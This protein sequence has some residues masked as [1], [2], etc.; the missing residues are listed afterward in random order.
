MRDNRS[1][2]VLPALPGNVARSGRATTDVCVGAPGRDGIE[3]KPLP[4]RSSGQS[5]PYLFGNNVSETSS[6][7]SF[8]EADNCPPGPTGDS[9]ASR[10]IVAMKDAL[11]RNIHPGK[12]RV[13]P[14]CEL[15]A[16]EGLEMPIDNTVLYRPAIRAIAA[17]LVGPRL[18]QAA[19]PRGQR[20]IGIRRRRCKK[21]RRTDGHE[22]Y[23]GKGMDYPLGHPVYPPG[24]VNC[25]KMKPPGC[26][27]NLF[28]K[29]GS[30][31]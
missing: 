17:R 26:R 6:A 14:A 3:G 15:A 9:L 8:N 16:D 21:R 19:E 27:A 7:V 10:I 25:H 2:V 24:I 29:L 4:A 20:R 22:T 30:R 1:G 11:F 28:H 12:W 18:M 31:N 5:I 23:R 13:L